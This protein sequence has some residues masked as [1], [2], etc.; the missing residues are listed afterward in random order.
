M[1]IG[2][3]KQLRCI[4]YSKCVAIAVCCKTKIFCY[5][6]YMRTERNSDFFDAEELAQELVKT[7]DTKYNLPY[8]T[9]LINLAKCYLKMRNLLK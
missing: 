7:R 1:L 8:E 4:S 2:G 9:R 6:P 3:L 5:N